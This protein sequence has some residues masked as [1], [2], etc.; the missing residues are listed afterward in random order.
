ME[1]DISCMM[2]FKSISL[3]VHSNNP[4]PVSGNRRGG[5]NNAT[6]SIESISFGYGPVKANKK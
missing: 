1:V 4:T 2:N 3:Y 5:G 6:H